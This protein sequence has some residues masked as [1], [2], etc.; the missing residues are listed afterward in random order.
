MIIECPNH[1]VAYLFKHLFDDGSCQIK[2][3]KP[4]CGWESEIFQ[5]HEHIEIGTLAERRR[6]EG[7]A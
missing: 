5:Q 7:E 2:C 6:M 4:E 1:K 3:C